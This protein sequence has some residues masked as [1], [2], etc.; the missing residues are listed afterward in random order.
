ML[1]ELVIENIEFADTNIDMEEDVADLIS[2]ICD[3]RKIRRLKE[4]N[5]ELD[6]LIKTEEKK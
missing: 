4:I 5:K 2:N 1:R 6:K 3:K